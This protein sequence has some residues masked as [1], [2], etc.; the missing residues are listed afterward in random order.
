METTSGPKARRG[1]EAHGLQQQEV[2]KPT[3]PHVG[4]LTR[5]IM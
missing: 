2:P 1:I 4:E 3:T 5:R